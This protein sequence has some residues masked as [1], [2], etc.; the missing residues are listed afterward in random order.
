MLEQ[1][2]ARISC[3]GCGNRGSHGAAIRLPANRAIHLIQGDKST[4]AI[5][6][7]NDDVGAELSSPPDGGVDDLP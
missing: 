4:P 6:Q 1:L 3:D 2:L 5:T 7:R